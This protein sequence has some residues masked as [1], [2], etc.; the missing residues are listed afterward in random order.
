M[1]SNIEFVE[2]VSSQL[3][4]LGIVRYRKMFGDYMVYVNEKPTVLICDNI[5]YVKKHLQYLIGGLQR[6]ITNL[7]NYNQVAMLWYYDNAT[8]G[9]ADDQNIAS[10]VSIL[11]Q[12]LSLLS[13][14]YGFSVVL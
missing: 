14:S 2:F 1:A 12:Y 5:A 6:F 10:A 9:S 4:K 3:E 8:C 7:R 11:Y 13:Y